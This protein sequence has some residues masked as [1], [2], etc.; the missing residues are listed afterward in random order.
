MSQN[1]LLSGTEEQNDSKNQGDGEQHDDVLTVEVATSVK[2]GLA[3]AAFP[4]F[5]NGGY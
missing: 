1:D 4:C 5:R 3:A 2:A